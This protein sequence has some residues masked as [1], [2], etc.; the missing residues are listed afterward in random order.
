MWLDGIFEK[1]VDDL[2]IYFSANHMFPKLVK[3]DKCL[4]T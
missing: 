3:K 1:I 4:E 2:F